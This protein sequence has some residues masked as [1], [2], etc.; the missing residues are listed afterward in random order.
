MCHIELRRFG[1]KLM[2][3]NQR[4]S[5]IRL[6]VSP[7]DP[8]QVQLLGDSAPFVFKYRD[9]GINGNLLLLMN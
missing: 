8:Q 9:S 2:N 5:G 4:K 3:V 6:A 1:C 7:K